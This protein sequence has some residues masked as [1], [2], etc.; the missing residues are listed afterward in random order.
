MRSQPGALRCAPRLVSRQ[1]DHLRVGAHHELRV[2]LGNGPSCPARLL[3]TPSRASS[4]PMKD[5]SLAA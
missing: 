1:H 4:S 5:A 2:E 3:A